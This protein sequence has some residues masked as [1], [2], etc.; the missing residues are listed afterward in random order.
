MPFNE[1]PLT[2]EQVDLL[3]RWIETG[4]NP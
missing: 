3:R 2:T 4:A 1:A